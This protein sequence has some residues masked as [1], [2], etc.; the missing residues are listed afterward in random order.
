MLPC[1]SKNVS[2]GRALLVSCGAIALC[3]GLVGCASQDKTPATATDLAANSEVLQEK[4]VPDG[5]FREHVLA[6]CLEPENVPAATEKYLA[7]CAAMFRE[8]SGSDGMIEMEIGLSSGHRHPLMLMTLGQLYLLA[9]QGN[10][11]LLPVEGPA[12]DLGSYDLNKPRLL[13]RANNLLK[14]ALVERPN[15]A[16]ID[17]L[18]ADVARTGGNMQEAAAWMQ[19]AHQKC[20]GGRSFRM[21]RMY[22]QLYE[23]PP[24]HSGGPAPEYPQ[25]AVNAG[26]SGDVILDLLL[27]PAGEVRQYEVVAS[28]GKTLTSAAWQSLQ[29][30][31]FEAARVGKYGVWS[32]LRVTTAFNLSS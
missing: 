1:R 8:G 13:K 7:Q 17:Y 20:T 15:D 27:S 26:V 23:Y 32:W 22:Q 28:P 25:A 6:R 4:A 18:L 21:L 31:E 19:S 14:E 24:R 2:T 29:K 30:G 5:A 12:A 9:G 10:P 3:W 16:A 11:D